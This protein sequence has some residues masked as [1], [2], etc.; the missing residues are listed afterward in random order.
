[1]LPPPW[2]PSAWNFAKH[3]PARASPSSSPSQLV[4]TSPSHWTPGAR[5]LY[6]SRYQEDGKSLNSSEKCQEERG[7]PC[8]EATRIF[9]SDDNSG[10]A[11]EVKCDQCEYMAATQKGLRQHIRMKHKEALRSADQSKGPLDCSSPLLSNTREEFCQN[12][13]APFSTGHQCEDTVSVE[14]DEEGIAE[15]DVKQTRIPNDCNCTQFSG[16][17]AKTAVCHWYPQRS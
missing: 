11:K 5:Q 13:E 3:W 8:K 14:P 16:W 10:A 4:L 7:V 9:N 2:S 15:A 1:M 12:C 6:K 17:H